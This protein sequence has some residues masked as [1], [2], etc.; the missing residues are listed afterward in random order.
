[1]KE[2]QPRAARRK[3]SQSERIS[4]CVLLPHFAHLLVWYFDIRYG[5]AD[6]RAPAE[7]ML[8]ILFHLRLRPSFNQIEFFK[9][10]NLIIKKFFLQ[11]RYIFVALFWP[12]S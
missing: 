10:I 1:M 11:F 9:Y 3:V 12:T 8:R 5:L 6:V 4:I 7:G 2:L